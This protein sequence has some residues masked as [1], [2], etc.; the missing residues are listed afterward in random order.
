ME[1]ILEIWENLLDIKVVE[2]LK[3]NKNYFSKTKLFQIKQ[4]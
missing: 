3:D 4:N 1:N 2:V